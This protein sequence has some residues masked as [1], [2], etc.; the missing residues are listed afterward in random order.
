MPKQVGETFY[1]REST[2]ISGVTTIY[3][4]EG[5]RIRLTDE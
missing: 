4:P 2:R 1:E 5:A 3:A